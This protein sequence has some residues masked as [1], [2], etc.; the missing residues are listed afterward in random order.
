MAFKANIDDIRDSLS[1]KLKKLLTFEGAIVSCS[2]E[3]V[4]NPKFI[5]KEELINICKIIVIGVPH[6]AYKK[7]DF[8]NS[9]ILFDIW[10]MG[11]K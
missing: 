11:K 5:S 6:D 10:S 3:F 7:I 9:V 1:F 8:P 4:K 2:D